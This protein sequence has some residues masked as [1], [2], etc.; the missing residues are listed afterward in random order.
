MIPFRDIKARYDLVS[1]LDGILGPHRARSG[2]YVSY[3]CPFHQ[4]KRPSMAAS[5]DGQYCTCYAGCPELQGADIFD[6][7]K[8]YYHISLVEA[9]KRLGDSVDWS[10]A[11]QKKRYIPESWD[12]TKIQKLFTPRVQYLKDTNFKEALPYYESRG[13]TEDTADFR[14]FTLDNCYHTFRYYEF[15]N[16]KKVKFEVPRY[17]IPRIMWN[18]VIGVKSRRHDLK[19]RQIVTE[20]WQGVMQDI[21]ADLRE[22]EQNDN[23]YTE[24]ELVDILFPR[25]NKWYAY[26]LP[27]GI[28]NPH[29]L[30]VKRQG[31]PHYQEWSYL[32]VVE[33]EIAAALLEQH[34][35]LAVSTKTFM[36]L[37]KAFAHIQRLL[38]WADN[39]P[40]KQRRDGTWYS[41]GQE[42]AYQIHD[43]AEHPN[44]SV[45]NCDK[46]YKS[47]DDFLL[48][49]PEKA[50]DW[51]DIT[52]G[53]RPKDPT[54]MRQSLLSN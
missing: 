51:L 45:I 31:K 38:I 10:K 21:I 16:G 32:I 44:A 53:V 36:N 19:A 12:Y 37:K 18:T 47:P 39:D 2:R 24:N 23:V 52:Y 14:N 46:Q 29:R 43:A 25:Y 15:L 8:S 26:G 27:D 33:S 40:L 22:R 28:Y 4:D 1:F 48:L 20:N 3:N 42:L 5:K 54:F 35:I 30:Y 7:V 50:L 34:G 11:P 41:P 9:A 49:A 17:I 13:F 6:F